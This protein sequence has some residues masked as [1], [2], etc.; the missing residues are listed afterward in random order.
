MPLTIGAIVM[1]SGAIIDIPEGWALCD[2]TNDTLDLRNKFIV[3]AGNTY[4]VNDTGGFADAT[5]VTHNH[6]AETNSSTNHTHS[7]GTSTG[8]TFDGL[9]QGSGT[10][11]QRNSG[12]GGTHTHTVTV[13]NAGESA[14]GK[15][16]PP[17]YALA[18]IQQI[19]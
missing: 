18:F 17:Y 2:G 7:Y 16:L 12:G 13:P 11:T 4:A 3:G 6:E 10:V 1:W 14:V 5:L 8:S 15:N 9:S 19:S